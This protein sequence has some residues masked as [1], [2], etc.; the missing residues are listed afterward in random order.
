MPVPSKKGI[1]KSLWVDLLCLVFLG[2]GDPACFHWELCPWVWVIAVDPAFIEGHQSINNCEIWIDQLDHLPA[3]MTTSFFLIFSEHLGTNFSQIFR[4]LSCSRIIVCK[5]PTLTSN[6]ALI[7]SID[8]RRFLS[9]KFFIWPINSGV[10]TSLLLLHLS[11]P[12]TDSLPSLNLLC[13]SKT[14]VWFMQDVWK[15][16]WSIPYVSVA[17]FQV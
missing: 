11:S 7:V 8:T 4:I 14:D 9:I 10:L 12:L 15:A 13:P 1:I 17:F 3:V 2:L 6:C 16:V 5:V